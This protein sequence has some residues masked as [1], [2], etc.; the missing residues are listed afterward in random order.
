MGCTYSN[1]AFIVASNTYCK[2]D[3]G[4]LRG[5]TIQFEVTTQYS[6]NFLFFCNSTGTGNMLHIE[7]RTGRTLSFY[8]TTTWMDTS[9]SGGVGTYSTLTPSIL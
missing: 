1:G 3:Y 5:K 2:I 4:S 8:T 9:F 6:C 7:S